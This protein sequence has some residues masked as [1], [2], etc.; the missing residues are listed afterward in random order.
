MSTYTFCMLETGKM[1][2]GMRTTLANVFPSYA[3]KKIRLSID[4]AKE[5]RSNDQNSYYWSAIV[6]FVRYARFEMGDPL[7]LNAVHEDLLKQFAPTVTVRGLN[8]E[9]YT[10][11]MRSKEMTVS[12]M[13]AYITAISGTMASMGYPV[14]V[15]EA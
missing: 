11:P 7:S 3:G 2:D 9:A 1:P 10:R 6:P 13:A 12:Q 14:P 4:E 8:G 15:R 5:K